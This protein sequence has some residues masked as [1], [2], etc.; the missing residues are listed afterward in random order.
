MTR[1]K[2]K[3]AAQLSLFTREQLPRAA[4]IPPPLPTS[5]TVSETLPDELVAAGWRIVWNTDRYQDGW[6]YAC[7][8]Q[9]GQRTAEH[10][11]VARRGF[12][13][14]IRDIAKANTTP[15]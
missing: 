3:P 15:A 7:N 14:A 11:Y 2:P 10:I 5:A 9:L 13:F 1:R 12:K 6:F 8:E 4:P